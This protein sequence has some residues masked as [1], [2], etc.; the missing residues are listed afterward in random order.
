M[1]KEIFESIM[2]N[3]IDDAFQHGGPQ[4]RVRISAQ[5]KDT[6]GVELLISDTDTGISKANAQKI[7]RPFLT[8]ARH[9]GGTGLG[10]AITRSLLAAHDGTIELLPTPAGTTFQVVI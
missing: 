4:A 2:V 8:T 1:D 5:T 3:L 6:G 9:Q 10:L 7:F